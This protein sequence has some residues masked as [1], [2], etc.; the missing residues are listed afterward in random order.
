MRL[1]G[2]MLMPTDLD[3]GRLAAEVVQPIIQTDSAVERI[4]IEDPMRKD[5][6]MP[7]A[8]VFFKE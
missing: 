3:T 1:I 7:L 4:A 8:D 6:F 2:I 5:G